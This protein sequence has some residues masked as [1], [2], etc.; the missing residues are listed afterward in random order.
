MVYLTVHLR[1][2]RGVPPEVV[3]GLS[4]GPSQCSGLS[5][6]R[7]RTRP[8]ETWSHGKTRTNRLWKVF[9]SD[10]L[11]RVLTTLLFHGATTHDSRR[12]RRVLKGQW[13]LEKTWTFTLSDIKGSI[14]EEGL[15]R[16]NFVSFFFFFPLPY[17]V[18]QGPVRVLSFT[19]QFL[20]RVAT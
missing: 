19:G 13:S 18:W 14:E 11:P 6:G 9:V 3:H 8:G 5:L 12:R 10:T 4:N 2:Y 1:C 16:T 15:W 20:R 17:P 7:S